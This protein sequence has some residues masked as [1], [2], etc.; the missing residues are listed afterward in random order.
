MVRRAHVLILLL[1]ATCTTTQTPSPAP[2]AAIPPGMASMTIT[3]A[4]GYYGQLL[5]IA[6]EVNEQKV[7]DLQVGEAHVAPVRPGR[8]TISISMFG[9]PGRENLNFTAQAGKRYR[10]VIE[11]REGVLAGAMVGAALLGP[12]GALAGQAVATGGAHVFQIV[13]TP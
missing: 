8:V 2:V 7:A 11:P 4:P 9:V 13:Q 12:V 6:V 3:R 5:S 10:F 1:L